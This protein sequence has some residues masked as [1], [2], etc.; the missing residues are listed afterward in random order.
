VITDPG[1]QTEDWTTPIKPSSGKEGEDFGGGLEGKVGGTGV[2][3]LDGR[4]L[5]EMG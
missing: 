3:R 4:G 2:E 5:Q 1:T